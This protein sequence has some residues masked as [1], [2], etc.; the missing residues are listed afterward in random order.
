MLKTPKQLLNCL[1]RAEKS[2][3]LIVFDGVLC[4]VFAYNCYNVLPLFNMNQV[5]GEL[6]LGQSDFSNVISKQDV[7]VLAEADD[8][9]VVREVQVYVVLMS[10]FLYKSDAVFCYP[11][12]ILFE[13]SN[14]IDW[15]FFCYI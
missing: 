8:Q 1:K 2:I 9:E 4:E 5:L 11:A 15:I 12:M 10:I 14:Y 3:V 13:Q 6:Y 7:K